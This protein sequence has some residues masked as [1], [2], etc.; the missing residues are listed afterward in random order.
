MDIRTAALQEHSKEN[1]EAIAKWVGNDKKRMQHFMDVFLHDEYRVVQRLS[2]ALYTINDMHPELVQLHIDTLVRY[3]QQ[4]QQQV[5]VKRSIVR[6]LQTLHI[7]EHLH[8]DVMNTCFDLLADV[9]E[10]VAV[11]VYSMTVLDNLTKHYPEIRQELNVILKEQLEQ[12][13]SA[14]F[15]SRAQKIL[16]N[17][18]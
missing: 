3:M 6:A 9:K 10:T 2:H 5:A 1:M 18:G 14:A 7:A 4:P 11:R 12:G 13:C 15:R 16:N 8:G 17:K